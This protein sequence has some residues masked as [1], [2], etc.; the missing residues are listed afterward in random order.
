MAAETEPSDLV[1]LF[2]IRF[3]LVSAPVYLSFV[4]NQALMLLGQQKIQ[5]NN[6]NNNIFISFLFI[7]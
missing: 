1:L 5:N 4:K 2:M 7:S 3:A 6:N